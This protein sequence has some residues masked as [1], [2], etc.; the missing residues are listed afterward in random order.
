MDTLARNSL[1]VVSNAETFID[2][3][4]NRQ[5]AIRWLIDVISGSE[6]AESHPVY[7]IENLDVLE[8]LG[9]TRRKGFRYAEREFADRIDELE[10]QLRAARELEVE[11]LSFYQHKLL[12]VERRI[13]AVRL[14]QAAFTP[15]PYPPM[16]SEEDFQRD[17]TEARERLEMIKSLLSRTPQ[18]QAMLE[19]MQPPLAVPVGGEQEWLPYATAWNTEIGRASCRERV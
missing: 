16:P 12:E 2:N 18:M 11:D 17:E 14:L 10:E 9:L 13:R 7:R 15:L 1:R 19:S 8:T 5:P 6:D 3:D 4:G